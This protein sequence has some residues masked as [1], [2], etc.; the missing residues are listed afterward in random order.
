MMPNLIHLDL[1]VSVIPQC[2]VDMITGE[3]KHWETRH[4]LTVQN[5]KVLVMVE[6]KTIDIF[7][8]DVSNREEIGGLNL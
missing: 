2:V 5:G 6:G 7:C 3:L 8:H 4:T 1:N